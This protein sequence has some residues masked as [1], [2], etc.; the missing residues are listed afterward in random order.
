MEWELILKIAPWVLGAAGSL[1]GAK[2]L[3]FLGSAGE[4][5]QETIDVIYVIANEADDVI[6]AL[7][8]AIQEHSE[9]SVL[10]VKKEVEE[11]IDAIKSIQTLVA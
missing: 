7:E 1:F 3:G 10:D 9:Q 5:L 6:P 11:L 8:K 2:I 4:K